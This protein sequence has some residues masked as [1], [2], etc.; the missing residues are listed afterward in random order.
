M[1]M[2]IE[3]TEDKL[4]SLAENIEKMLRYGGKAMQCIDELSQE[5]RMGERGVYGRYG[6]R[7]DVG[8]RY[9]NRMNSRDEEDEWED[10]DDDPYMGER[11][12][13]SSR[14]GRYVRR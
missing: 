3:I 9:G 5:N 7:H 11:R 2:M 1:G 13:R 6:N 4:C 8:G 12:G 14:T 10:Y